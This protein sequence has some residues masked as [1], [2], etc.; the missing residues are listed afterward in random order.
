M[1][2]YRVGR[3]Q[4]ELLKEVSDILAHKVRDPRVSGVTITD[5]SVTG[6]FQHAT[7]YYST[8]DKLAS[9]REKVAKGLSKASGLIRKELANRLTL[10]KAPE[11]TFERD[12]SVDYGNRIDQLINELHQKEQDK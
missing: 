4:Q 2:N 7:I 6:D 1:A 12:S 9:E 11:I 8:L 10:Y 3:L 5:V